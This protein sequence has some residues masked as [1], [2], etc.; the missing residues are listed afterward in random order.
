MGILAP[1]AT[2]PAIVSRL[3]REVTAILRAADVKD[4]L[5]AQG[6]EPSPSTLIAFATHIRSEIA[7]WRK[8][9]TAAG[10]HAE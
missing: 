2:S 6:V 3:N 1:A 8:F 7:K 9:V 4:A 5:V 10:V